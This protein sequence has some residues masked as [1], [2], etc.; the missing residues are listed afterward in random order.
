MT[1]NLQPSTPKPRLNQS[2]SP[3]HL[4]SFSIRLCQW[5][6][7]LTPTP[8]GETIAQ[9]LGIPTP[10][11]YRYRGGHHYPKMHNL[12]TLAAIYPLDL[13]WLITG[14]AAPAFGSSLQKGQGVPQSLPKGLVKNSPGTERVTINGAG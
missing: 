10:L 3:S 11:W 7:G 1:T 2:N 6:S 9:A 4:S 5:Q 13:H 8:S 12:Q 14:Q